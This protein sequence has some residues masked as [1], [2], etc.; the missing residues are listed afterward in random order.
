MNTE[1]LVIL[2]RD[3]NRKEQEKIDGMKMKQNSIP[4][5][6]DKIQISDFE[7]ES[8]STGFSNHIFIFALSLSMIVLW[9]FLQTLGTSQRLTRTRV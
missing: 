1:A 2:D 6:A 7:Q 3:D 9:G 5:K 4:S 8:I